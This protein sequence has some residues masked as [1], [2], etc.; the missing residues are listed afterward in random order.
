M[1]GSPSIIVIAPKCILPVRSRPLARKRRYIVVPSTLLASIAAEQFSQHQLSHGRET[2]QRP[3]IYSIGAWLAFAG[4]TRAFAKGNPH[5][6]V[7]LAGARSMA[8][9]RGAGH[10]DCSTLREWLCLGAVRRACWPSGTS[11]VMVNRGTNTPTPQFQQWHR[12]FRREC[13]ARDWITRARSLEAG[14]GMGSRDWRYRDSPRFKPQLRPRSYSRRARGSGGRREREFHHCRPTWRSQRP[15]KDFAASW[16]SPLV[17][18]VQPS[19]RYPQQSIGIFV[20]GLAGHFAGNRAIIRAGLR[21]PLISHTR[22]AAPLADQ[23]LVAGARLLL[24]LAHPVIHYA[25]CKFD[26]SDPHFC[27]SRCR[28]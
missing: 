1:R 3:S 14:S 20:S 26:P 25:E 2:W 12:L 19:R 10:P 11:R 27:R 24:E 7:S 15:S 28:A 23:P 21:P 8:P 13:R 16:N 9:H 4:A 6:A 22:G 5:A 18:R 17:A